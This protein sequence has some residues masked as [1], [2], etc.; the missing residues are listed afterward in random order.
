MRKTRAKGRKDWKWRW[1]QKQEQGTKQICTAAED[2]LS[3]CYEIPRGQSKEGN[4]ISY[5][6]HKVY[7]QIKHFFSFEPKMENEKDV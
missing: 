4:T 2:G 3:I 1:R 5:R 6:F 7:A